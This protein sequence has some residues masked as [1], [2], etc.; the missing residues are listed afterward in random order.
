MLRVN[1][2]FGPTIQGEGPHT[3]RHALFVRLARCHLGCWFCV[4]HD[5]RVLRRKKDSNACEYV[6]VK[7]VEV[8]DTLVGYNE[9]ARRYEYTSVVNK[10]KKRVKGFREFYTQSGSRVRCTEDH[11]WMT[12]ESGWVEAKDLKKGTVLQDM[13][14]THYFVDGDLIIQSRRNKASLT[15]YDLSCAPYP[16]F[17]VDHLLSHNCDSAYTWATTEQKAGQHKDKIV[18]D[19]KVEER[20]MSEDEVIEEL[21]S[22]WDIE[23]SP[24][25][26]VI[27]GG[28]PL[29][30]VKSLGPLVDRLQ[31]MGNIVEF[32][33]SGSTPPAFTQE[34]LEKLHFNV[35]P[36]LSNSRVE[37]SLRLKYKVLEQFT[38]VD[39]D[40]KFV[41]TS[42]EDLKEVDEIVEDLKVPHECVWIMPEGVTNDEVGE[43]ARLVIDEVMKR[44]Y[45][46]S[47]RT[48]ISIWGT[49]RGR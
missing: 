49:E 32:E 42:I 8:G 22:K 13:N 40:F 17:V 7:N 39:S 31:E 11:R 15:V 21:K 19:Q 9:K 26:I 35:S 44:K 29:L 36:K 37:K 18:F 30:Q 46:F 25:L 14:Q 24:T 41:V 43:H 12:L 28:E 45:N 23:G 3:G 38:G 1:E 33:T 10:S 34:Q 5:S 27:T 2:I 20:L 47:M 16:S 6:E 4:A 48:H